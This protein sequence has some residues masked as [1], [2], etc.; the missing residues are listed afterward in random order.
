VICLESLGQV[1]SGYGI[2]GLLRQV[3]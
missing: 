1:M 2:L 3:I